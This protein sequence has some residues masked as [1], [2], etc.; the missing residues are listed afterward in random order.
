MGNHIEAGEAEAQR[1]RGSIRDRLRSHCGRSRASFVSKEGEAMITTILL[2]WG[3]LGLVLL[4]YWTLT[5]DLFD[6]FDR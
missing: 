1:R 4:G 6:R 2:S 5:T 3:L